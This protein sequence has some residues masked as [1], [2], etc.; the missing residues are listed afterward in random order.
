MSTKA[1]RPKPK[2]M[3]HIP[4]HTQHKDVFFDPT[5]RRWRLIKASVLLLLALIVLVV[6]ASWQPLQRSPAL[7]VGKGITP[8]P[9]I[10]LDGPAPEIG[11]GPLIRLVRIDRIGSKLIATDP[12]T[13]LNLGEITG[14]DA[15]EVG[16]ASIALQHYGYSSAAHKTLELTFDDGPDPTS[17]PKILDLLSKYKAA[18]TFFVIGDEVVKY[19]QIVTREVREG[20]AIGNHTLTHPDLTPAAVQQQFVTNDRIIRATTG[21]ATK[22]VRLPYDGSTGHASDTDRN[23]V[24]VEVERLG[25][26]DSLDE[27]DTND[28][29]YGDPALRPKVPIPLPPTTADNLT[30]LLHDGGGDRSAT[31]EYLKR[32]LP[33]ALRHGYT[34]HTLPQVSEEALAG[35]THVKPSPWDYEALWVYQAIW[36]LPDILIETLFVLAILFLMVGGGVNV[37]LALRRHARQQRQNIRQ[38]RRRSA[39]IPVSIAVAAYNEERVIGRTLE[40]LCSSRYRNIREIIVVDDGS[41]DRTGA[42]VAE[43]AASEPRIRLLRQKNAGKA[44]ALN[45]AFAAA[46]SPIVVTLDAD[47]LFTPATVDNLVCSF[48]LDKTRRLAAVAGVVKVG[49]LGSLLT[50]WQA[51]EYITMIGVDRAAQDALQAIMVVPGACAAWSRKAVLRVGGYSRSTLAEDCDLALALQQVG[52]LVTQADEA[53]C[54]TEAPETVGALAKQR[55]RWMYGTIQALWK[56]R[57]MMLN[58][59]YDWLGTLTLPLA[60]VSVLLPVVFLPFVYLMAAV[61][62]EGQG[63]SLVVLYLLVFL[64]MQFLTAGVGIKLTR[65]SWSHLLMVPLYRLIYEP[66]RAYILYKSILTVLR[67]TRSSWN[68]LQRKGTV[69]LAIANSAEGAA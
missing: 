53:V 38:R 25:Y 54:Y 18:A 42:I 20:F 65:E 4:S 55:F 16:T 5:G 41:S 43:M 58:P 37:L 11:V 30:I 1:A 59:S 10:D 26:I 63:V 2:S 66:L 47:T 15:A 8:L 51:L 45:H 7:P 57:V 49:N 23:T 17:T 22:L 34:F 24:L 29:E 44:A 61:T 35:T 19:P 39:R 46:R 64:A 13:N 48:A 40:A 32:L 56:H 3:P 27:F 69:K 21:I 52:Y 68:K 36:V 28:W 50:R 60:A 67:G 6:V 9:D 14:D 31:V 12:L 62:F 33:W